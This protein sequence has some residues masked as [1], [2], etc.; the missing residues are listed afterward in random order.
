MTQD[1]ILRE[2][3]HAA[4]TGDFVLVEQ[5]GRAYGLRVIAGVLLRATQRL[6]TWI[7]GARGGRPLRP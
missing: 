3:Q 2:L 1:Q 4:R 5:Q 7:A 6:A